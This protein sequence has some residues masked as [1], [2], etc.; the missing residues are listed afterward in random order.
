[1][2]L[3]DVRFIST[4][5]F[6]QIEASKI[7]ARHACGDDVDRC[8]SNFERSMLQDAATASQSHCN[9][10]AATSSLWPLLHLASPFPPPPPPSCKSTHHLTDGQ[11]LN[12]VLIYAMQGKQE[13]KSDH[14][15]QHALNHSATRSGQ[16]V[17]CTMLERIPVLLVQCPGD[18]LHTLCRVLVI[19]LQH[20]TMLA[21]KANKR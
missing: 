8:I 13:H 6:L 11:H 5:R 3:H 10:D 16:N 15:K 14:E 9:T 12:A 7:K 20:L 17:D 18:S 2:P 19:D 21:S 4:Y 1:M